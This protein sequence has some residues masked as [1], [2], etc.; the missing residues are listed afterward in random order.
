MM[1]LPE[2]PESYWLATTKSPSYDKLSAD[3]ETAFAVIGGG[4]SGITTAYLLAKAG[5]RVALLTANKLFS[6]T[7]GYTTAKITA[8]HD[9]IYDEYIQHFGEEKAR[10][11]YE[12][13]RDGGA[14]IADIIREHGI[15]CDYAEEDAYVYAV[16][17]ANVA[18]LRKEA[19]AYARLGIPG[20]FVDRIPLPVAAKGAVVMRGQAHFHPLPYLIHLAQEIVRLGGQI[21]EDTTASKFKEEDGQVRITTADGHEVVCESVAACSHFPFFDNGFYFARLHADSSYVLALKTDFAYPGGMYISADD[22]KRSIRMVEYGSERLLLIGGESHKT[23]QGENTI[24]HYEALEDYAAE[25]FGRGEIRYRWSTH[26]FATL[27]KLPYIGQAT[28]G[29]E[30]LFV[31]TG[32]RKWGMTTGAVAAQLLTDLMLGRDNR[33]AELYGPSRFG[34]DPGVKTF[35]QQNAD[36]AYRL[37]H[38]K[39]EWLNMHPDDLGPDQGAAVRIQG[40]RAGAYRD[41]EGRLHVVDTTCTHMGCEVAWNEGDRTWD[42][43]CH[44]SRFDYRGEVLTGP[45]KKPLKPL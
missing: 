34:A 6:G 1:P 25:T 9:L 3:L 44:G 5:R 7:T 15:D 45:A 8:Q 10:L 22:P 18:K 11:H 13:N 26:D 12:A 14:F 37:V 39:L 19:E 40:H 41:A 43:P 27:D 38:G 31:A 42:C 23:G 29:S 32:Y 33:Y 2:F 35:V 30:R 17:E 24:L 21:F 16:E 36:V 4:I 28:K 20:E